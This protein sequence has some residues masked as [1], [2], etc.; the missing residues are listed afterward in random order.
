MVVGSA[1]WAFALAIVALSGNVSGAILALV[2]MGITEGFCVNAQNEFFLGLK[3]SKK[4]GEDQAIGFY[5]MVGKFA[6]TLGPILFGAAHHS[7]AD[8]RSL[9]DCIEHLLAGCYLYSENS[10][11]CGSISR[12]LS[13]ISVYV[14]EYHQ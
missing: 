6:E 7:R 3:S 11:R 2:I 10:Q 9:G 4:I 13:V 14:P 5:E 1:L 8:Y 12:C